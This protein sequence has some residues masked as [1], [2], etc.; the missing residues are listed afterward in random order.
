MAR[1]W[2]SVW[3]W[4]RARNGKTHFYLRWYDDRGRLRAKKVAGGTKDAESERRRHEHALNSGAFRQREP[5]TLKA[6]FAEHLGFIKASRQPGTVKDQGQAMTMF[7]GFVGGE[8]WIE[9]VTVRAVERFMAWRR[10]RVRPPTANKTLRT[11]RAIFANAVRLDYIE[12]NPFDSLRP[13]REPEKTFRVLKYAEVVELL[14]A[15][16]SLRWRA[17]VFLA[18]TTGMRLGELLHLEWADVDFDGGMVTIRNKTDWR[19]KTARV[20][21]VPLVRQAR[22]ILAR[23]RGRRESGYVFV[24]WQGEAMRNNLQR[25]F[26]QIVARA[27]IARCRMKDLRD[28]FA[29]TLAN[30]G[31]N[32]A[33]VQ[34]LAG[35]TNIT[36]TLRHYTQVRD[37]SM[38]EATEA[39]SFAHV[40]IVTLSSPRPPARRKAET[41]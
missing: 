26:Q 8:T 21:R 9:S 20:R 3:I 36:T 40:P 2:R 17:L 5:I 1:Q 12:G 15:C 29:S 28:T 4:T 18:V 31:V 16:P 39:L 22:E 38:V 13:V 23:L 30:A 6:F 33:I 37:E 34:R 19:T 32:Q 27:G 25:D 11:L 14:H 35:H 41:A 24:T 7:A 10:A